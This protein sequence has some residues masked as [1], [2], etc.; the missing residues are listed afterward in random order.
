MAGF[1]SIIYM[2][3]NAQLPGGLKTEVKSPIS[4]HLLIAYLPTLQTGIDHTNRHIPLI[5]KFMNTPFE[6]LPV[7]RLQNVCNRN[8]KRLKPTTFHVWIEA[9]VP[10]ITSIKAI[11]PLIAS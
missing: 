2:E 3:S 5:L 9:V 8:L 6:L 10:P 7:R 1:D 4:P 11:R